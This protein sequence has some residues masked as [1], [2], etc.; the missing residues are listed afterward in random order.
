M[1]A[2]AYACDIA[3]RDK[4]QTAA[5][6]VRADLGDVDILVNN[7]GIMTTKYFMDLTEAEIR[8]T[9][10]VNTIAHFWAS[11]YNMITIIV[12]FQ[13]FFSEVYIPDVIGVMLKV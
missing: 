13:H 4:V 3:Q 1:D 6:Q 9:F 8:K 12:H 5:N 7:A 10:E 11:R 2:R